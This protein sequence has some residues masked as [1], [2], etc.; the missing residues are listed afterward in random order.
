M[1]YRISQKQRGPGLYESLSRRFRKHPIA[2]PLAFLVFGVVAGVLPLVLHLPFSVR[3]LTLGIIALPI[4]VVLLPFGIATVI[5]RRTN[6]VVLRCPQ[7]GRTSDDDPNQFRVERMDYLE[8][9]YVTCTFCGADFTVD[10][11]ARLA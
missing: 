7:C 9:A 3:F 5:R 8:Y 1:S 10:K 4:G 2:M 11:Y 6:V